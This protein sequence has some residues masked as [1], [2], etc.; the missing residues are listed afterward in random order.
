VRA[1]SKRELITECETWCPGPGGRLAEPGGYRSCSRSGSVS[2]LDWP[3][4]SGD[5]ALSV[6]RPRGGPGTGRCA[7]TGEDVGDRR[8]R[9]TSRCACPR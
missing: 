9:E 4:R 6:Q 2:P 5:G 8:G 7:S 1:S 3:V